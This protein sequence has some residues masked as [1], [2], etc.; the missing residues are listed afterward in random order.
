MDAAIKAALGEEPWIVSFGDAKGETP[1][2]VAG[3]LGINVRSLVILGYSAGC[4]AVRSALRTGTLPSS[5]RLGVVCIDG[6]HASIPPET[7]QIEVWSKLGEEAR[8]GEKLFVATC[9][10]NSY[11]ARLTKPNTPYMPT[12]AV[13]R[14]AVEP[15]LF[16]ASPPH[17]IHAGDLHIYAY[18]SKEIDKAAHIAQQREVM[19]EMLR[20]H[21]APW[22]GYAADTL[23][24][25][26]LKTPLDIA[27]GYVGW[28]EEG[29]ANRGPIVRASLDGC[30]RD[31]K[32]L[33][34]KEGV[35]WCAAFVG[36][37][38]F[39]AHANYPWRAAVRE[40]V[41]DARAN[42]RWRERS[43]MPNPGDLAIY[44]RGGKDPRRGEEGHVDR[45]IRVAMKDSELIEVVGGNVGDRVTQRTID[46][47]AEKPGEELVGWIAR[48][49]ID[50]IKENV[51]AA[52]YSS[53]DGM[54]RD[55]EGA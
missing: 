33:G 52:I 31:G 32:P 11:T 1:K 34:I 9:T 27:L 25:R 4:Q 2:S 3:A 50:D 55:I 54:A 29:G 43:Y 8:K 17:E 35:A 28:K 36:L 51:D 12:L 41:E 53:L 42:G 22:L 7:W 44:K 47:G 49:P 10:D 26:V 20:K 21:V 39:E 14:A 48:G 19:P 24:T 45:V 40:L 16:P 38:D 5:Q 13:L 23:P 46:L 30:M 18:A 6:T 15:A 37:C